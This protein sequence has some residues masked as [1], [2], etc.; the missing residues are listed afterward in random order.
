MAV[1]GISIALSGSG[2]VLLAGLLGSVTL[3]Q[4]H[5]AVGNTVGLLV[6]FYALLRNSADP[7]SHIRAA[8]ALSWRAGIAVLGAL[9]V[10]PKIGPTNAMEEIF[11]GLCLS[12]VIFS[13]IFSMLAYLMSV[14]HLSH[15]LGCRS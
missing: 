7:M 8:W 9:W 4:W 14:L 1:C 2:V 12:L 13:G 15:R 5:W 6:I 10:T 11:L 3:L